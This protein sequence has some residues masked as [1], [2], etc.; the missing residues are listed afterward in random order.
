[1]I[2]YQTTKKE[3]IDYANKH[4]VTTSLLITT[5]L[6]L[7]VLWLWPTENIDQAQL[8][9]PANVVYLTEL[10]IANPK[11]VIK[12]KELKIDD[13]KIKIVEK[14]N[15][16][17]KLQKS[18]PTANGEN[19]LPFFEANIQPRPLIDIRSIMNYPEQA[20]KMN[21][22]A[23]VVVEI[24]IS[25][26]GIVMKA[27]IVRSAGW[28]FDKEVLRK[29]IMVKFKPAIKDDLPIAVTVQIPLAFVLN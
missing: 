15:P 10:Q 1:M 18:T 27:K 4:R 7:G 29:I 8:L 22:Q 24:D 20:R 21:I 16:L 19:F 13:K 3:I 11:I 23:T 9:S 28:G 14:D 6:H 2:K 25:S 5:L 26:T 12:V 17:E